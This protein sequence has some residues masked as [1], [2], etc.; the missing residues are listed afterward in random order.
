MSPAQLRLLRAAKRC[1]DVFP[2]GIYELCAA[3]AAVEGELLDAVGAAEVAFEAHQ[4]CDVKCSEWA[5]VMSQYEA[6]VDDYL[7]AP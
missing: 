4:Q 2:L 5:Q 7:E 6:A 1:T 3:V